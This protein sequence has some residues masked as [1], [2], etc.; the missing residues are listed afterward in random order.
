MEPKKR[1]GRMV[2]GV[3]SAVIAMLII[4]MLFTI[5]SVRM[6]S[7]DDVET[8]LAI[9]STLSGNLSGAGKKDYY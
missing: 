8:D 6:G 4:S 2:A 3:A 9:N 7:A 1:K 5:V